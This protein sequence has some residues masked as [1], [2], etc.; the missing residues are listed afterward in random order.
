M[1]DL[2]IGNYIFSSAVL[3]DPYFTKGCVGKTKPVPSVSQK[4]QN[5]L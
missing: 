5:I 4:F 2:Q 1:N 3:D